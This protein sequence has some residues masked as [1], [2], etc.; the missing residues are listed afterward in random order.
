MIDD[1][2]EHDNDDHDSIRNLR[3][4]VIVYKERLHVSC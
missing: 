4:D 2:D 1:H 3:F